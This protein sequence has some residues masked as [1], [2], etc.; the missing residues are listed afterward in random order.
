MQ[1]VFL[2]SGEAGT[3]VPAPPSRDLIF[4]N[5]YYLALTHLFTTEGPYEEDDS[6]GSFLNDIHERTVYKEFCMF[7]NWLCPR[8]NIGYAGCGQL[9]ALFADLCCRRLFE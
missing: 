8:D 5:A 4:K 3:I 7:R 6:T 2:R 1:K 9:C